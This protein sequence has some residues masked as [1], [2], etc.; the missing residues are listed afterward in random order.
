MDRAPLSLTA[1]QEWHQGSVSQE[2]AYGSLPSD[3][4]LTAI[5]EAGL[6]I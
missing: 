4:L 5:L 2:V 1:N 6:G 3:S